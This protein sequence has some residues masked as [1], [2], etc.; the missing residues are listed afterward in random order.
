MFACF[1]FYKSQQSS[2]Q[3]TEQT[4]L[5]KIIRCD[6]I[7]MFTNFVGFENAF[8]SGSDLSFVYDKIKISST[9]DIIAKIKTAHFTLRWSV[10]WLE[11]IYCQIIKVALDSLLLFCNVLIL[12]NHSC[13]GH[14]TLGQGWISRSR[15]GHSSKK[16][17]KADG[18]F[19]KLWLKDNLVYYYIAVQSVLLPHILIP[20]FVLF[21]FQVDLPAL[22]LAATNIRKYLCNCEV[23]YKKCITNF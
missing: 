2:C 22:V 16:A 10:R 15:W 21:P 7:W 17:K 5:R 14:W 11:M 6:G 12:S 8:K 4:I 19:T 3:Q 20:M 1:I 23:M 13:L 18:F 9:V